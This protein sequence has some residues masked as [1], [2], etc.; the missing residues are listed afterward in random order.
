MT[1][2]LDVR[3]D[4][5]FISAQEQLRINCRIAL[6]IFSGLGDGGG[7]GL[8]GEEGANEKN[9]GADELG[10]SE[11]LVK[12]ER[13]KCERADRAEQLET[14]RKCDADL[15]DRDVI[16]DVG[17]RDAAHGGDNQDE[18]HV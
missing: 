16:Q 17:E 6:D 15:A 8:H 11:S 2:C 10:V 14:L 4:F 18:I 7:F 3:Y 5:R 9:G 12:N 1:C 13:G